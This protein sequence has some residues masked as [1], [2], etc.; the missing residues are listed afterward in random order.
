MEESRE[1]ILNPQAITAILTLRYNPFQKS[2]LPK[3]AWNDVVGKNTKPSNELLQKLVEDSIKSQIQ[4]LENERLSIALSGGIDSTLVLAILRKISP[5]AEIEAVSL[6]F[7]DSIDETPNAVKI[8]EKFGAN[9]HI[10][11]VENFLSE[12]PRAISITKMPFWD[13]HWYYVVKK[14]RTLSGY[15]VSGDGGD[16]LFG[17]YTFRYK[18]FLSKISKNSTPLE[19][20]K[21]YLDCHERDWVPD[22]ENLFGNKINF[23][24][25]SIYEILIP[26]FDNSLSLI[27]QVFLADYNGKLLYNF[28]PINTSIHNHFGMQSVAPL[29]SKEII[30][31]AMHLPHNIK[32]DNENDIGKIQLRELLSKFVDKS[33]LS[34][35]KLGFSMNT[36]EYWKNHGKEIYDYYLSEGNIVKEGL[37]NKEWITKHYSNLINNLDVRYVNKFLGLLAFE[38][39]YRLFITKEMKSDEKL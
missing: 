22:Q 4:N 17:G 29:L 34:E 37:I 13:L 7:A 6:K 15:L 20:V 12:L 18:K 28:S 39:W 26:Y 38:V 30:S 24:W 25:N 14:S 21:A 8:A 5:N 32:Y 2:L 10:V 23:S 31:Y 1:F 36:I 9:H 35:K 3:L 33:I 11:Y 19:K 27:D 16:E